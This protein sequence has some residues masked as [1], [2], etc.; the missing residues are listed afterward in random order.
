MLKDIEKE[1]V[2]QT[3]RQSPAIG[4]KPARLLEISPLAL[5]YKIREYEISID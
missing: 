3:L 5:R 4:K 1:T 2:G